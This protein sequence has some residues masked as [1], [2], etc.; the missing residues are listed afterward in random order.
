MEWLE[1]DLNLVSFMQCMT[2]QV[3]WKAHFWRIRLILY[4]PV[5]YAHTPVEN[6]SIWDWILNQWGDAEDVI[7]DGKIDKYSPVITNNM[8]DRYF[9]SGIQLIRLP[10]LIGSCV[11]N[12]HLQRVSAQYG[13]RIHFIHNLKIIHYSMNYEPSYGIISFTK[14]LN[15]GNS[16]SDSSC[17]Y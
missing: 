2:D 11:M 13:I 14:G 4:L 10:H 12:N 9:L 7:G 1:R 8:V 6:V 5:I 16:T 17:C 3:Q 15:E